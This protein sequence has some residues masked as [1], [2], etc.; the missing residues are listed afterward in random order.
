MGLGKVRRGSVSGCVV[1]R[2]VIVAS[3]KHDSWCRAAGQEEKRD[4]GRWWVNGG[5]KVS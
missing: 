4:P 3:D 2:R 5:E 1:Q